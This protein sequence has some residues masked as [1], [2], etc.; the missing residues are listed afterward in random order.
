MKIIVRVFIF[1]SFLFFACSSLATVPKVRLIAHGNVASVYIPIGMYQYNSAAIK[2]KYKPRLDNIAAFLRTRPHLNAKIYGYHASKKLAQRR[3]N[4]TVQYFVNNGVPVNKITTTGF[5]LQQNG[6]Q[7]ILTRLQSHTSAPPNTASA[8]PTPASSYSNRN[9][10][11]YY[12]TRI[13]IRL[14]RF[15]RCGSR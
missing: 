11:Q 15:Q 9:F 10:L 12:A 3:A 1:F 8:Q 6:K 7:E 13:F 2:S 5:G 14:C 4:N